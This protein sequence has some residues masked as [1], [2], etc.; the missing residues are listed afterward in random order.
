MQIQLLD[1]LLILNL[2]LKEELVEELNQ[3]GFNDSAI[4]TSLVEGFRILL[5]RDTNQV[6]HITDFSQVIFS[7]VTYSAEIFNANIQ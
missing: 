5:K 6:N 3:R 1:M 2:E 7:F 4:C